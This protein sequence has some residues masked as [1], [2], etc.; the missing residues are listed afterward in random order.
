MLVDYSDSE[1]DEP[2]E[3]KAAAAAAEAQGDGATETAA[4]IVAAS[5]APPPS[6]KQKVE[7][8][9]Q[10]LL[11]KHDAPPLPF[12]ALPADFFDSGAGAREPDA[13]EARG[14]D[15]DTKRSRGWAVLSSMLPPPKNVAGSGSGSGGAGSGTGKLPAAST[16]SLYHRAQPLHRPTPATGGCHSNSDT[17]PAREL[18]TTSVSVASAAAVGAAAPPPPPMLP[19]AAAAASSSLVPKLRTAMYDV[20][21]DDDDGARHP[22]DARMADGGGGALLGP[23]LG[24]APPP[25]LAGG[26]GGS[27]AHPYRNAYPPAPFGH[28]DEEHMVAVSQDDLRRAMGPSQ[29]FDYAVPP[30]PQEVKV[31]ASVWSRSSGQTEQTYQASGMQKR[32]NQINKL[33][34]E[35][36][37]RAPQLQQQRAQGTKTKKETAAKYGW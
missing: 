8:N 37:T 28:V 3:E 17:A 27:G 18:P 2:E 36:A 19:S 7:I 1:E 34:A 22:R 33:A 6:K 30:P 24:P 25:P 12:D 26:T 32:K 21:D 20:V 10:S 15:G 11:Q 14:S 5:A 29:R 35:A 16:S 13:G 4:P 23:A 31:A 9:L